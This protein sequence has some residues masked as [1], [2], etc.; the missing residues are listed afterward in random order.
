VRRAPRGALAGGLV[1]LVALAGLGLLLRDGGGDG[2]SRA[3]GDRPRADFFGLVSEDFFGASP[4]H[5]ARELVRQ[6]RAGVRLIRQT[7]DWAR[8]E[9]RPGR[10]DFS[11]YDSYVAAL[12]SRGMRLLPIVFGPPRF[13]STAPA[14]GALRGTYPP[15]SPRDLG[16]FA[17]VLVRRYGPRGTFWRSHPGLPRVPVRAWQVWNEPNLPVYWRPRPDAAAYVRL[18][19]AAR[20]EIKRADP[21]AEVVS[22]AVAYS[23]LGVPFERYLTDMYRAG[24]ASTF[25]VLGLNPYARDAPGVLVAVRSARALAARF[26][27]HPPIW[28]TE[29]GWAT[30]GPPSVFRVSERRQA[31]LVLQTL[32]LLVRERRRLGVRGV[33]YFNWKDSVP[34]AGGREFFGLHTGLLRIDRTAKPALSS[35]E[36]VAEGR[37]P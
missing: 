8:I 9:R 21:G 5:R 13:R 2:S 24:A 12:A 26:G 32:E 29:I 3:A 10:Y 33:V 20:D 35:Y 22:A 7:F 1:L 31:D 6:R 14:L 25:D 37:E 4:S 30:G 15:R 17:A 16:R 11:F 27:H 36:K 34:Y 23:T 18:L 28:L 19:R